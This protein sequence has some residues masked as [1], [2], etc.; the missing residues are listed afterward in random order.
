MFYLVL[1]QEGGAAERLLYGHK[2]G[3]RE[4]GGT[5]SKHKTESSAPLSLRKNSEKVCIFY[6]EMIESI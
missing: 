4:E 3:V 2:T 5:L 6:K 1:P